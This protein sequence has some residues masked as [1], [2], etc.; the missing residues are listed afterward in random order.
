M[1]DIP[2]IRSWFMATSAA[3]PFLSPA[4]RRLWVLDMRYSGYTQKALGEM[5]CSTQS[6]IARIENQ[7]K[8][9]LKRTRRTLFSRA[10]LARPI[11]MP[12]DRFF[13]RNEWIDPDF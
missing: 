10:C 7:A 9:E 2:I 8:R 4:T 3:I 13:P 11:E 12:G 1:T 6:N 5:I